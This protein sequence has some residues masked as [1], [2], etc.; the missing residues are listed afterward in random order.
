[1]ESAQASELPVLLTAVLVIRIVLLEPV[2]TK[3][4]DMGTV[5]LSLTTAVCVLMIWLELSKI[6]TLNV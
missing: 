3:L 4:N 1:M 5:V 6:S 2:A